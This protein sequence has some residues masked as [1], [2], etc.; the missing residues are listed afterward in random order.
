MTNT[1]RIWGWLVAIQPT[2]AIAQDQATQAAAT[3]ADW[4]AVLYGLIVILIFVAAVFL[5]FQQ[6]QRRRK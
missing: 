3:E 4:T 6:K 5:W 1:S 2:V